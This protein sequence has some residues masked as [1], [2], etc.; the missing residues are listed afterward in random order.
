L[1]ERLGAAW[2]AAR[3][4]PAQVTPPSPEPAAP[5]AP[6]ARLAPGK[7]VRLPR[8]IVVSGILA[9]KQERA[10]EQVAGRAGLTLGARV[11]EAEWVS[12]ELLPCEAP[13]EALDGAAFPSGQPVADGT[14]PAV[15]RPGGG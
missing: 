9:G 13:G 1:L 8:R 4:A 12:M 6:A 11:Y 15:R 7:P 3:P 5:P 2:R 10:L 14:A